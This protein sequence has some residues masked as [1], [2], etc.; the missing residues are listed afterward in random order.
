QYGVNDFK[1][2][3][4]DVRTGLVLLGHYTTRHGWVTD[5]SSHIAVAPGVD[6]TLGVTLKGTTANVTLNGQQALSFVYNGVTVDGRFGVLSAYGSA[7]FDSFRMKTDDP[8]LQGFI[9]HGGGPIAPKVYQ[10]SGV[11][12]ADNQG[13]SGTRTIYQQTIDGSASSSGTLIPL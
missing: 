7:S 3:A 2:A 13:G 10:A 11:A 4:Y 8:A 12:P 5:A 1:Y 9:P 6:F